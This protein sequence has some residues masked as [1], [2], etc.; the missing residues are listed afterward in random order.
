[1]GCTC[2]FRIIG[3][4]GP[5]R[6]NPERVWPGKMCTAGPL[7]LNDAVPSLLNPPFHPVGTCWP[8]GTSVV[9]AGNARGEKSATS[10]SKGLRPTPPF[11]IVRPAELKAGEPEDGETL[12]VTSTW[13]SQISPVL[14]AGL[15]TVY[16]YAEGARM[17]AAIQTRRRRKRI[18]IGDRTFVV[19]GAARTTSRCPKR[20]P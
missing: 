8:K 16:R 7:V 15:L 2:I 10:L 13:M 12:V 4:P 18:F 20:S 19:R 17:P 6:A 11:W 14:P 9:P 5:S 3:M 1:M